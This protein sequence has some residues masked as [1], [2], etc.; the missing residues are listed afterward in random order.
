M[1]TIKPNKSE[2]IISKIFKN[3]ETIYGLDEFKDLPLG[4]ILNITEQEPHRFYLKDL[5][6]GHFKFVYDEEKQ[7]GKPEE[8]IRQLWIYK[9]NKYYGYPLERLAEE[10]SVQFGREIHKK[11]ADIV[12]YKEDK[13]TPYIIFEVKEPKAKKAEEQLKAYMA[14][15]WAEGGVWSNGKQKF[16]LYRP[17]PKEYVTTFPEI[18]F[19]DQTWDDLFNEKVYYNSLNKNFD[20]SFIIRSLEE[21]VLAQSGESVFDEVFKILYAKLYDEDQAKNY[22]ENHEVLFKLYQ[23]PQKTYSVV[24]GNLFSN[25]KEKWTNIFNSNDKIE[26]SPEQLQVCVP[27]IQ[28]IKLFGT[29]REELEIIDRAFEHLY[30]EVSKGQKGQYFT[31]RNVIKMSVKMLNPQQNEYII[32]PACGSGGFLLHAMYWIW[33]QEL[34]EMSILLQR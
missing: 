10:V 27:L 8:L 17:F 13:I 12:I 28:K 23:D 18:P 6:K 31:P 16:I 29:G 7:I 25:S 24:N 11:F 34:A 2:E 4:D 9:L 1:P 33:D 22:R 32:D 15:Q 26:L 30:A 19:A 21:M 5:L 20:L 3:Q 14:G